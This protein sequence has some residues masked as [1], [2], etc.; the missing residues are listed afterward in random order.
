MAQD[1]STNLGSAQVTVGGTTAPSSG[2][3]ESW[4]VS[5]AVN[6]PTAVS[7]TSQFRVI[8]AASAANP[9]LAEIMLITNVSGTTWS[10]T[11]GAEAIGTNGTTPVAHA[12]GWTAIVVQTI[13]S[14]QNLAPAALTSYISGST[15]SLTAS[16][17][18]QIT[19]LSL[20]AG[21][22]N[23][24]GTALVFRA[25]A[26]LAY[27]DGWLG[28][29]TASVTGCYASA[30]IEVGNIAGAAEYLSMT[31]PTTQ[32]FTTTTTVYL[33]A[34]ASVSATVEYQTQNALPN[35]TGILAT[36]VL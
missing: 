34:Y 17:A 16:T 25:T 22:W 8:D 14:L 12:S 15:V 27:I 26:S 13:G 36:P 24:V 9:A 2:T 20:P 1:I 4:T 28:P 21:T 32:T 30:E 19:S 31:I 35:C 11:R 18:T 5:S 10:A 7:G 23:I 29:N 33:N 3:T 6:V